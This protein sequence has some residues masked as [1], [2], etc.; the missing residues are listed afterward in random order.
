MTDIAD[1]QTVG[2]V[3]RA[4]A[5]DLGAEIAVLGILMTDPAAMD[6]A[7]HLTA[8][9]F[10]SP[11]H[12]DIYRAIAKLHADGDPTGPQAVVGHLADNG[13]LSRVGG[14]P[15]ITTTWS[16]APPIVQLGYYLTRVTETAQ[17]RR[18]EAAGIQL[19]HAAT[20]PG[21]DLDQLAALADQIIST[22]RPE[23]RSQDL[24]PIGALINPCLEDIETRA[25][26]EP[27][28]STGFKDLD[29]LLGGVRPAELT[30]VAGATGMGKS[31]FLADVARHVAF[32]LGLVVA[33][34]SLEM[35]KEMLFD[36]VLSAETRVPHHLIHAGQ[37]GDEEWRRV[38]DRLGPMA[39][40]PL[41]FAD[42]PPLSVA[43]I[44]ARCQ[45][46]QRQRGLD[47]VLVDHMH[48]VSPSRRCNSDRE[49]LEDVSRG[50]KLDLAM[51]LNLPVIAAAQLN[52]NPSARPDKRPQLSDLKHASSIEQDSDVVILLHREDYYDKESPRAGEA[53]FVVAKNRTGAT[54]TITVAAQFHFT[55]FADM[56]IA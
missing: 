20:T 24:T 16:D 6:T 49:R 23:R 28:I 56:A 48:L 43:Q 30:T 52:R 55:R 45:R 31:I 3:E 26:R 4:P 41:F 42:D 37:L 27:G 19:T 2:G 9:D 54:D 36:R 11:K 14:A 47:L 5:Y 50:L 17:V 34:F 29:R 21:R 18:L 22:A 33:Y 32:R 40:A 8:D 38:T 15:F 1:R 39:Q 10:Y 51:T 44:R 53:D 7:E 46:L 13:N 35:R 12:A 25:N